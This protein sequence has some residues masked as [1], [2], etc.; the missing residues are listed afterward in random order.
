[1][2]RT[3]GAVLAGFV[4]WTVLWLGS[5]AALTAAMPDVIHQDGR[6]DSAGVLLLLLVLSVVFSVASGYVAA[7]IARAKA[8][9]AAL[10]L[11]LL[12]LAVGL[13][14]QVQYWDVM[15][16]WYHVSFLALL[17]PGAMIGGRLRA[18]G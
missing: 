6:V 16:L 4:L 13:F 17:V 11:G 14:V 10:G 12:L 9:G 5:N 18:R 8:G 3:I 2:G 7:L 1:M 15:P